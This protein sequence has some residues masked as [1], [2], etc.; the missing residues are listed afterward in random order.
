VGWDKLAGLTLF[1]PASHRGLPLM[2]AVTS[3]FYSLLPA[4]PYIS[5]PQ[6]AITSQAGEFNTSLTFLL[7]AQKNNLITI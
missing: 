6:R 5:L 1:T 4:F 3:V 7:R 2:P